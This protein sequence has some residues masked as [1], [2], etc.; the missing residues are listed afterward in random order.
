VISN[1]IEEERSHL[2]RLSDLKAGL[3][4]D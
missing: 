1:I 3:A 2:K 4:R